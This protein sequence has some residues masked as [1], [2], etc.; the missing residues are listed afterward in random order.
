MIDNN[1]DVAD[2]DEDNDDDFDENDSDDN[3]ITQFIFWSDRV[4]IKAFLLRIR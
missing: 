2:D 3:C 1:D 4:N